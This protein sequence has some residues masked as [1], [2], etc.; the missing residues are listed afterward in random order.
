MTVIY[1]HYK[2]LYKSSILVT[3]VCA[4]NAYVYYLQ[5]PVV[6]VTLDLLCYNACQ[7]INYTFTLAP[8]AIGIHILD[9]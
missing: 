7:F 1:S 2:E 4:I 3:P 6:K 9:L 8:H 5:F